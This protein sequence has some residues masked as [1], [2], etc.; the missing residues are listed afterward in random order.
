MEN[1]IFEQKEIEFKPN[2]NVRLFFWVNNLVGKN[3]WLDA[4]GRAG[5]EFV[6]LAM[7]G[8]YIAAIFIDRWPDKKMAIIQLV[9]SLMVW[10]LGWL[11]DMGIGYLVK[12]SRPHITYPQSKLLFTPMMVWKSFPSDH[13]MLAWLLVFLAAV[14]N[15]PGVWPLL[16]LALWV[17]W[18]RGYAGVH[19][20]F[21]I[22]GGMSVAGLLAVASIFV[23]TVAR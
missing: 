6:I 16:L 19:Y 4:F 17:S 18:G 15:L 21:D 8:W 14:F 23:M 1:Q 5:A 7:L 3:L 13:A 22:V 2:F 9:F 10:F 11:L 20:P 12:E